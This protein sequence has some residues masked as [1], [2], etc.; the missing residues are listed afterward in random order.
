MSF[1]ATRARDVYAAGVELRILIMAHYEF[2]T[3]VTEQQIR[4]VRVNDTVTLNRTLY[5]IRDATQIHMFDHGRKTRFDL[6]GHAVVHT[7]PNVKWVGETKA[8]PSGYESICI[9]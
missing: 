2:D 5:G 9:G 3:P 7:A 8:A 6:R 1:C 4:Q